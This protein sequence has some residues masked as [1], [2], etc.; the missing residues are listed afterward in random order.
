[1]LKDVCQDA[2][3]KLAYPDSVGNVTS[4]FPG[5]SGVVERDGYA[6]IIGEGAEYL[7]GC[8]LYQGSPNQ[9]EPYSTKLIYQNNTGPVTTPRGF[10]LT[11]VTGLT[12]VE[13]RTE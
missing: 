3:T 7:V 4:V 9:R 1:M 11:V 12:L 8:I 10:T 6:R 2:S 13:A 5:D